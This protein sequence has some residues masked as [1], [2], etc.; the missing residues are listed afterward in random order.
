MNSSPQRLPFR[1]SLI[2]HI[3]KVSMTRRSAY[4]CICITRNSKIYRISTAQQ[5]ESKMINCG[6]AFSWFLIVA[7]FFLKGLESYP[8]FSFKFFQVIG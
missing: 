3:A 8:A 1:N 6:F 7:L 2:Q 5:N 4:T